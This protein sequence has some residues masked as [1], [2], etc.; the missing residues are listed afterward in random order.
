LEVP[1]VD[2]SIIPALLVGPESV[3]IASAFAADGTHIIAPT[4]SVASKPVRLHPSMIIRPP[5]V[6]IRYPLYS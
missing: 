5:L 2:R 3:T 1:T 6:Q 4:S